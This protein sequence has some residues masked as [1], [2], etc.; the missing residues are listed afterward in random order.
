MDFW[1]QSVITLAQQRENMM[2]LRTC[3]KAFRMAGVRIGFAVA[4]ST[5]TSALRAVKSPYNINSLS[6]AAVAAMLSRPD[7]IREATQ[8]VLSERDKLYAE[9]KSL[10]E[11]RPEAFELAETVANFF[12]IKMPAGQAR[13]MFEKLKSAGIVVRLMGDKLRITAGNA[14]EN[15]EFI[16]AFK[17]NL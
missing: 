16:K 13:E 5:L 7:E 9:M 12:I 2:V 15:E 10:Q 1:D 3:S 4:N 14:Q 8:S 11:N 17:S 6:Q